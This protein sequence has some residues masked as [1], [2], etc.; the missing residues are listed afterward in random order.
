MRGVIVDTVPRK[1]IKADE[2]TSPPPELVDGFNI[3][4]DKIKEGIDI[5]PHL[6]K[7]LTDLNYDD[8]LLNDWGIYHLHLGTEF[9]K[10]GF[11]NRTGP[12]L[13]FFRVTLFL[14]YSNN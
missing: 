11:V 3:L 5:T 8:P 12:P 4:I 9:D 10:R 7:K 13:Y 6:S 1:I 14:L 2:F